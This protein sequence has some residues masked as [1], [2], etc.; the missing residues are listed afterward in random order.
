MKTIKHEIGRDKGLN[1][2]EDY[3]RLRWAG[4]NRKKAGTR[5]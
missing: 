3:R 1:W 4:L 2:K 5:L